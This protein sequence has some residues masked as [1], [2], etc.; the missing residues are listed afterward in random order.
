MGKLCEISSGI[1]RL[2]CSDVLYF[3]WNWIN[4]HIQLSRF[5]SGISRALTDVKDGTKSVTTWWQI[6]FSKKSW[7]DTPIS[8]SVRR[9][10]PQENQPKLMWLHPLIFKFVFIIIVI[11][12]III[13]IIIIFIIVNRSNFLLSDYRLGVLWKWRMRHNQFR[14]ADSWRVPDWARQLLNKRQAL[15]ES[16]WN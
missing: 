2:L 4:R 7:L 9:E 3:L 5:I 13:I 6:C 15:W 11:I 12:D 1:Q 14:R 8:N 10:D 16:H